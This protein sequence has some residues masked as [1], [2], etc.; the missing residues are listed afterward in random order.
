M[1]GYS[2]PTLYHYF[3]DVN[4]LL[5]CTKAEMMR[6]LVARIQTQLPEKAGTAQ[7]IK[8]L[9]YAYVS[10]YF[11]YPSVF[12]FFY[13]HPQSDPHLVPEL[14][15]EEPDFDSLRIN[16]FA[17]LSGGGAVP[18]QKL[19]V[20]GRTFIYAVHGML[21]LHFSGHYQMNEQEVYKAL[22]D[23]VDHLLA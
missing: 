16:T 17:G 11:E 9:F 7:D 14:A 23:M 19:E 12:R 8:R 2:Y 18:P 5:A 15:G 3:E 1:A 22:E 13:F 10:Y 4:T 21:T 6:T 20:L